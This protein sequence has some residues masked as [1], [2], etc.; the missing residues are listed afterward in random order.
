MQGFQS[1]QE[2]AISERAMCELVI[3]LASGLIGCL[4]DWMTG[5]LIIRS[6]DWLLDGLVDQLIDGP[7]DLLLNLWID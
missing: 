2:Q 3:W 1:R 5:W 4:I 7:I 6:M